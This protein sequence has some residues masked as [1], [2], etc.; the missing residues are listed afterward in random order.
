MVTAEPAVHRVVRE[1]EACGCKPGWSGAS[2]KARCPGHDDKVASLSVSEADD[3][4]A[5]VHCH[6]G[7]ATE[8][9][10]EAL[11]LTMRD[12]FPETNGAA[13]RETRY[14]I[15]D[16][17]G[18]LIATHVR[19]DGP[20]GKRLWWEREG[21][22]GLGGLPLADLPLYCAHL[23]ARWSPGS[24]I[25]VT[26]GEKSC[27]ALLSRGIPALGTV[28]GAS[29]CPGREALEV[30]RDR[31]VVLWPDHDETG[32]AHMRR[33]DAALNGIASSVRWIK[34]GVQPGDD[35]ADFEG[36]TDAFRMLV[37][38]A[39]APPTPDTEST[40]EKAPRRRQGSA[41]LIDDVEPATEQVDGPALFQE[42]AAVLAR[43]LVIEAAAITVITLWIA[44]TYLTDHVDCMPRLLLTSPTRA[45]GK[46]RLLGLLAALVHRALPA[47][48]ITPSAVFR[49]IDAA[50]PTLLLDEMDNARLSE[51]PELLAVL[52]SGHTR[53]MAYT[54]RNVGERHEP[55]R[56]STWA[57]IAF[58]AIDKPP[59]LPDTIAS[60]SLP[61]SMRRRARTQP[62]QRMR[63][64]CISAELEPVRRQLARWCDDHAETIATTDPPVPEA[65]DDRWA[66]N[67]TPLLSIADA[68]GGEWRERARRALLELAGSVPDEADARIQ[69]LHDL[70]DVFAGRNRLSTK[71]LIDALK[72]MEDRPW[73][74]W[75]RDGAITPRGLA[76]LLKGFRIEPADVRLGEKVLKGYT[77]EAFQDAW[78]Q[79]PTPNPRQAQ[80]A[81]PDAGEAPVSEPQH[82]SDVADA[83]N[84]SDPHQSSVVADVAD[85]TDREGTIF[86]AL[87][88]GSR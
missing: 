63:Q 23:V 40:R 16:A 58:A 31:P 82:A 14:A 84:G 49:I 43:Y 32:A 15:H 21:R 29:G 9:V 37:G 42:V 24:V 33:V 3:G 76:K 85:A 67:A 68:A 34:W 10:V 64:G 20:D 75:S 66:D 25:V 2:F 6:A 87:E 72:E 18:N 38:N 53:A 69:L 4:R 8:R 13:P 50:H 81:T 35:A 26:E 30:L 71:D 59:G 39:L 44:M 11:G 79:Y 74:E 46:S 47:S 60:R 22:K 12:L 86:R 48:S 28:T 7:C 73:G 19:M 65:L 45:C 83:G 57:P 56:F 27:D 77:K 62:V 55:R 51:N 80:Q 52:N 36:S 78:L 17:A 88:G 61:I 5:L 70:R 54:I 1:L 41:L